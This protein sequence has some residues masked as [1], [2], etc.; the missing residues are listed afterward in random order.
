MARNQIGNLINITLN[1]Y[2]VAFIVLYGLGYG[3]YY[4]TADMAIP[5]VADV[6]DYEMFRSGNYAPGIIGTLF[7]FVDKLVSSLAATVVGVALTFVG[8]TT[9]PGSLHPGCRSCIVCAFLDCRF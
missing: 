3:A 1:P 6:S 7:S 2:T 9:L 4:S 5:M 8:L